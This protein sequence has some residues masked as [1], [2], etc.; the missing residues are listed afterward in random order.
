MFPGFNKERK[1]PRMY[2]NPRLSPHAPQRT[3]GARQDKTNYASRC[4]HNSATITLLCLIV[5]IKYKSASY[6]FVR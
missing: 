5:L 6:L 1:C 4:L 3:Q 2:L